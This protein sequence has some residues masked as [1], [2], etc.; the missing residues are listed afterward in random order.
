MSTA[1]TSQLIDDGFEIVHHNV[2]LLTNG[3]VKSAT[4]DQFQYAVAVDTHRLI[5]ELV[6]EQRATRKVLE[7]MDRRLAKQVKL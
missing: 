4:I 1:K 2:N 3:K 7:R 6:K 5:G